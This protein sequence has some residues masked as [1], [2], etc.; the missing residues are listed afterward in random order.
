M[1]QIDQ[2]RWDFAQAWNSDVARLG[3]FK[4]AKAARASGVR[5]GL[6]GRDED[7]Q[8]DVSSDA[9][10]YH[11][12]VRAT[13]DPCSATSLASVASVRHSSPRMSPT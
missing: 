7:H 11:S 5:A 6:P 10:Q 3:A 2:A 8:K 9:H 12:A 13:G 4:K 1:W